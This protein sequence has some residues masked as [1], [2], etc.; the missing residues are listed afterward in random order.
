MGRLY[1]Q[2]RKED[3]EKSYLAFRNI[4]TNNLA[5][6]A[7]LQGELLGRETELANLKSLIEE[8]EEDE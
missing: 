4:D 8:K 2:Q 6:F 7:K 3:I 1:Y 5:D